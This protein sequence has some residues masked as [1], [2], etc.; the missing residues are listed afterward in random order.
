MAPLTVSASP[1]DSVVPAGT[2]DDAPATI[3]VADD[4]E[5][6]RRLLRLQLRGPGYR[7]VECA[8]GRAALEACRRGDVELALLDIEMP[9]LDGFEVL[10]AI[11]S[12]RGLDD[13]PVILLTAHALPGGVAKGLDLGAHDYLRKPFDG[14]ELRARVAAAI[15]L[16][17]RTAELSEARQRFSDFLDHTDALVFLKDLDGRYLF[18]NR[19]WADVAGGPV[20]FSIGRTAA[21]HLPPDMAEVHQLIDARVAAGDVSVTEDVLRGRTYLSVKFPVR[22]SDG[23]VYGIGGILTDIT[24]RKQIEDKVRAMHDE[25]AWRAY[26]D[27]LTGL[28]NRALLADRLTEALHS[29]HRGDAS[30]ALLFVDLDRFKVVND[31]LGHATGDELLVEIAH[32]LRAAIRPTDVVARMGGDEFVVLVEGVARAE[33]LTGLVERVREAIAEPVRLGSQAITVTASIGIAVADGHT[34][35]SLLRDADT[36]LYRAKDQGRNRFEIFDDALRASAV[37]RLEIEGLVREALAHDGVRVHYQPIVDLEGE[38]VAVEALARLVTPDG[39]LLEPRAFLDVAE[40]CGLIVPLGSRVLHEAC[41]QAARWAAELGPAA[42]RRVTVNV[43]ARQLAHPGM[44]GDAAEALAA[45]G[46]EPHR[47][48]LELTENALIEASP[49]TGLTIECLRTL[50]VAL[51]IDDFGTGYASLAYLKRFPVDYLKIDRSFVAGLGGES[52]DSTIVRAII[53]LAGTLGLTPVAEGVENAEQL[54]RLRSFGCGLVQG[55]YVGPPE[56][57]GD[58]SR[59]LRPA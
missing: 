48:C 42:P 37:R 57:A 26:H 47:L 50:G 20:G 16:R 17:R 31:S 21:E 34:A 30:V 27:E 19:R 32:R 53:T 10:E 52:E 44:V 33:D 4:D 12:D 45:S 56:P 54:A 14:N 35:E 29:A 39:R 25:L 7:I 59:R 46:L 1:F 9:Y 51:A 5:D 2:G 6:I 36:A 22:R 40:E 8:D 38:I 24:A 49:A 18:V 41:A 15:K 23:G 28:P 58:L 55:W 43:S 3:V 13:L 11:R